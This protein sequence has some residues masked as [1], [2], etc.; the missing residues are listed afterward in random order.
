MLRIYCI[1]YISLSQNIT[2]HDVSEE[3]DEP[4]AYS[5]GLEHPR[6]HGSDSQTDGIPSRPTAPRIFEKRRHRREKYMWLDQWRPKYDVLS[7]VDRISRVKGSPTG[8]ID[9]PFTCD[10]G[11]C[12][13]DPQY[14]AFA[15][16][17]D[18]G[19]CDFH[20]ACLPGPPGYCVPAESNSD[21]FHY[22]YTIGWYVFRIP[23][24]SLAFNLLF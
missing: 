15:C 24:I 4:F 13:A 5:P 20:T 17:D 11:T 18:V 10:Y 22:Y 8:A 16:C 19:S 1:P 14:T 23:K 6:E 12:V 9:Q 3:D 7:V 2:Y 21:C